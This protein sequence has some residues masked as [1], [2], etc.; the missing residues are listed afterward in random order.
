MESA[1][2]V[3]RP[4]RDEAHPSRTMPRIPSSSNLAS[5]PPA[6]ILRRVDTT[7]FD[8]DLPP[9]SIAQVPAERRDRSRLLFVDRQTGRVEDLHFSDLPGV[10]HPKTAFLRNNARVLRARLHARRPT[11][12]HVE[13]LLL[14]PSARPDEWWCLLR[15]GRKLDTGTTFSRDGWF[16]ATVREK[17]DDGRSLV[18]FDRKAG[19]GPDMIA[20][21]ERIGEMPLPPYIRREPDDP[22]KTLD[23][24]RYNTIYADPGKTVAAAAPTAGLHFT[25]ELVETLEASGHRFFDLTLHVGLDTFRPIATETIEAHR[26]HR[27]TYEIPPSTRQI[28]ESGESWQRLAVGTTS[29]RS[30]ED[31]L[32]RDL[33]PDPSGREGFRGAAELFVY[34]PSTFGVEGLLTNFHLP[35]S[36]L[37]CLVA[38]FLTPG[39]IDG[40]AWLKDLYKSALALD[41][42]FYSY[43]DAMLIL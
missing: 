38:A 10:L 36:T 12:G 25:S 26:I 31:F 21:A 5:T 28:L 17:R 1:R 42:R 27:E 35:R 18:A 8:Y 32:R 14:H 30:C 6:H 43:G 9:S 39:S 41:Y 13:C 19:T 20:L 23:A 2:T 22:R 15:P 29:L 33:P 7:L 3:I 40:I 24:E 34:P 11:G 4:G 37:M 16:T